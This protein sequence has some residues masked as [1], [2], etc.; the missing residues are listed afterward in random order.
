MITTI[1][2][3]WWDVL[4]WR[5]DRR[6]A[7]GIE[8]LIVFIAIVLVAAVS[9]AVLIQTVGFLQ[10][11]ATSTGRETTQEV[12]SGIKV[13]K[14]AGYVPNPRAD[15]SNITRLAIYIEPNTGGQDID[16]SKVVI[17]LSD[18]QNET[19]LTYDNESWWDARNGVNN[20]FTNT[21]FWNNVK[22]NKF[23]IIVL[24]DE[25][26]SVIKDYPV[27]NKGDKVILTI[28]VDKTFG[29]GFK[30]RV[31]VYGEVRPEHGAPGVIDFTTPPAYTVNVIELQ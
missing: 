23:G 24:E 10:Q 15:Y 27:L 2:R 3:R 1:I 12:A 28:S 13:M 16:L 22:A 18:G 7:I 25:D 4:R 6:G 29:Q 11:K 19:M 17:T 21:T 20:T 9:A 26:S 31:H 14:V 30:P 8:I 5:K